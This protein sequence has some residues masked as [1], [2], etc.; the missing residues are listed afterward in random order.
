MSAIILSGC[1]GTRYLDKNQKILY[2]QKVKST[3]KKF[4]TAPLSNLY[5]AKA[6]GKLLGLPIN[7]LVWMYRAGEKRFKP[8][9]FIKKKEKKE[10]AFARKMQ[11]AG[12]QKTINNLQYRRLKKI[13]VLDNKI[14][15]GNN[16]MQWGEKISIYDSA[17]TQLTVDR[18]GH[19]M[20]TKGYFLSRVEVHVSERKRKVR[21]EYTVQPGVPYRLD[22]IFYNSPDSL[23]GDLIKKKEAKQA[24]KKGDQYDEDN[25]GKERERIDIL[26]R[27]QG[28]YA[29]NRQYIDFDVDTTLIQP[30]KI[31]VRV[32]VRKPERLSQHI[33]YRLDSLTFTPD[34]GIKNESGQKRTN[35]YYRGILFKTIDHQYNRKVLRQRV[36]IRKDSLYSR[37]ET[38]LTQR[39]LANL[40]IFKF[41][42]INY[43]TSDGKFIAH[44]FAS[45][46]ER[47]SWGNE[48]GVSV[49]QGF[50]GPYYSLNFKKRNLFGGLEIFELNGRFGYEGVASAA[51]SGNYTSTEANINASISLPQFLLPLDGRRAVR[52]AKFNPKTKL[53]AGYTYTNRPEYQRSII[54]GSAT[55]TWENRNRIQYSF[56]PVNLN[57]IK[58]D[59]STAFGTLLRELESN[60]NR[61]INAF[62]P[63][64][65]SSMTVSV[66][67]NQ[68]NYGTSNTNSFFIR[69]TL[70]SG[71]TFL[72]FWEP[73]FIDK[74]NLQ[75]YQYIRASV[76]MRRAQILN[77]ITQ[78]AFR[79]NSGVGYAY[80]SN[81]VLPYEKSFF[82]G[83]SNSVRAWRPR[84]LGQGT[85]TPELSTDPD[86]NGL[87][88]YRF[89]KPGDV[90]LEA[91]IEL[92]QKL[93]GFVNYAIFVDAGNVWTLASNND[94]KTKFTGSQFY[95]EFGVGTGF[96]LRFDFN[97]LILRLDLGMKMYDPARPEGDRFVLDKMKFFKPFGTGRE[98]V[99]YNIGI[100]Y[101]F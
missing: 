34:V 75:P 68:H 59:T 20:F 63:S 13:E 100:G 1:L 7:H 8:E 62:K 41:V 21:V 73:S 33:Q 18:I 22:S 76:D 32:N 72:N 12:S 43:D 2:K 49:T 6:N 26:L 95:N 89:E 85:S 77:K 64:L 10:K 101:P 70:E 58:S 93:F 55:Y 48:A 3:S 5:V 83:G 78:V 86:A 28:Y 54:T 27:D 98:P 67:W 57:I 79:L 87:Y 56:T 99:I 51:S 25:F 30:H 36:F 92:R 37:S 15:N 69:G 88:N 38:F 81:R 61:L 24:L 9:K 14:Q 40:D 60:G 66:T 45:P 91:S 96:G 53:L 52:L 94:P 4:D 31:T 74:N 82:V 47:Y 44:I 23:I 19:Y 80:S 71:G 65:V 39:Q 50:P 90:L 11:K 84:R 97:F 16:F 42:N 29:F 35:S 46:L 17:A